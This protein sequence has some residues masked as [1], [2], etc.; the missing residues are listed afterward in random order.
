MKKIFLI[1][2]I[3]FLCCK[4]SNNQ[5]QQNFTYQQIFDSLGIPFNK[6]CVVVD[7]LVTWL[8]PYVYFLLNL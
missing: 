6:P 7:S 8:E 3:G 4:K 5:L 2:C 1:V